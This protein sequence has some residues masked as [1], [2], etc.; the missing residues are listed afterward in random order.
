MAFGLLTMLLALSGGGDCKIGR[1]EICPRGG[2]NY[3][4]K[5]IEFFEDSR[6]ELYN[7]RADVSECHNL[8]AEQPELVADLQTKLMAWPRC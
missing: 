2:G 7:I 8:V 5:L 6:L 1:R 4:W 3:I